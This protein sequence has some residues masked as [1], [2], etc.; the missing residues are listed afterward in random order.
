MGGDPPALASASQ[1]EACAVGG[2]QN[3]FTF[4]ISA[5]T[6]RTKVGLPHARAHDSAGCLRLATRHGARSHGAPQAA[7]RQFCDDFDEGLDEVLR[8]TNPLN[9]YPPLPSIQVLL[10]NNT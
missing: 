2:A 8:T 5:L 7:V 4:S 6:M 1:F 9:E 10:I 3:L